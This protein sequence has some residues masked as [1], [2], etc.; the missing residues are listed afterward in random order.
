V[1]P[2]KVPSALRPIDL[3]MWQNQVELVTVKWWQ[4]HVWLMSC[5]V[6]WPR[7]I[8]SPVPDLSQAPRG[9]ARPMRR[10]RR[11]RLS[12]ATLR[13]KST[14]HPM[15]VKLT[16]I[17]NRATEVRSWPEAAVSTAGRVVRFRVKTGHSLAPIARVHETQTEGQ[18]YHSSCNANEVASLHRPRCPRGGS[19]DAFDRAPQAPH[20]DAGGEAPAQRCDDRRVD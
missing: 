17:I 11:P 10:R 9:C 20:V 13:Q 19:D 5:L 7:A 3:V 1:T 16:S 6:Y 18:S 15:L 8:R 12:R 14:L 2:C 4:W